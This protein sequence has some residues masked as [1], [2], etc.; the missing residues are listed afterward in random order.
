VKD[1]EA[2]WA[3]VMDAKATNEPTTPKPAKEKPTPQAPAPAAAPATPSQPTP[4]VAGP[5]PGAAAASSPTP[6]AAPPVA[7]PTAGPPPA[8]ATPPESLAGRQR[9]GVDAVKA[10]LA[11]MAGKTDAPHK[12]EA[13]EEK[14]APTPPVK[15]LVKRVLI[16]TDPDGNK[17][18]IPLAEDDE[19]EPGSGG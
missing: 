12:V 3:E 1:G 7:Q 15:D 10:R 14:P 19:P 8:P 13:T 16:T 9:K 2:T 5:A 18:E 6:Q 4:K 17:V 11:K